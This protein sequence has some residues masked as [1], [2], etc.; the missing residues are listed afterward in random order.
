M[1][2]VCGDFR[3]RGNVFEVFRVND[4]KRV[5]HSAT[6]ATLQVWELKHSRSKAFK[7]KNQATLVFNFSGVYTVIFRIT[8]NIF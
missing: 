1:N 2:A 6:L 7:P 5:I 4:A 3:P 8:G